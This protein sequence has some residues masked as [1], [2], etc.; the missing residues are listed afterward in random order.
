MLCYRREQRETDETAHA[1][2]RGPRW[3][4][5]ADLH[6]DLSPL[7][8]GAAGQ[9]HPSDRMPAFEQETTIPRNLNA[10]EGAFPQFL[11]QSRKT[12]GAPAVEV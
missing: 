1:A 9:Q 7:A 10:I 11:L 5:S 4:S 8:G 2:P 12:Q 3:H 6:A